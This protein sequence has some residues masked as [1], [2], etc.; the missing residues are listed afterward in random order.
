MFSFSLPAT[1]PVGTVGL[2]AAPSRWPESRKAL[3]LASIVTLAER[4]KPQDGLSNDTP[5]EDRR[6]PGDELAWL[7]GESPCKD[8]CLRRLSND[9]DMRRIAPGEPSRRAT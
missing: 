5:C 1:R 7:S 3:M 8:D 6:P 2:G 4:K 9:S